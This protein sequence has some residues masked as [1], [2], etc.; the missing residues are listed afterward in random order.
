M[1]SPARS[2]TVVIPARFG[3]SRFPTQAGWDQ[4]TGYGRPEGNRLLEQEMIK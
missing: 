3:S 2:V 1:D 4:F